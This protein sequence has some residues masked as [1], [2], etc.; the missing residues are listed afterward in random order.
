[1]IH[2]SLRIMRHPVHEYIKKKKQLSEFNISFIISIR[3]NHSSVLN[4]YYYIINWAVIIKQAWNAFT[5]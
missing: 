1:M 5:V 2:L 4:Q 3:E